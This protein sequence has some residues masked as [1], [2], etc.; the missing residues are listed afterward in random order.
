MSENTQ[1]CTFQ[2]GEGHYCVN[3]ECVQEVIRYQE[4]TTVPLTPDSIAGLI[5]LRGQIVTAI[6]MRK[7]L[8]IEDRAS[9]ARPMN[10]VVRTGDSAVSLLVDKIGDVMEVENDRFEL[11]P[12]TLQG[13]TR[14]LVKGTY[15]LK[16]RLLLLLDA[17]EA[18]SVHLSS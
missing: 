4:M 2:L 10:V 7:R 3:A 1:V 12:A 9:D 18:T 14:T 16:D 17:T 11:P 13:P 8:G 6:D 15:K 5:N